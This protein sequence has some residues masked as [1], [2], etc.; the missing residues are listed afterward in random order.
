M[1]APATVCGLC[2]REWIKRCSLGGVPQYS[3]NCSCLRS[4]RNK[5][6][7]LPPPDILWTNDLV[8]LARIFPND[9]LM[10][11]I[12]SL[13][14]LGWECGEGYQTSES[15]LRPAWL[16][17]HLP[18]GH[19]PSHKTWL[20]WHVSW[21]EPALPSIAQHHYRGSSAKETFRDVHLHGGQLFVSAN[22]GVGMVEYF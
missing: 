8:E 18:T 9:I 14:I 17:S 7:G 2:W 6:W 1:G 15:S 20:S 16:P 4:I 19:S 10:C 12:N 13:W 11:R 22:M 5:K 3:I 21:S